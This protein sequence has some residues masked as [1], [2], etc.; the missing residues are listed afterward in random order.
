MPPPEDATA[1]VDL[2]MVGRA[3]MELALTSRYT[4][5]DD[6]P[7]VIS[8]CAAHLGARATTMY[9]VDLGQRDLVPLY[10]RSAPSGEPLPVE[11][12]LAGRA[13][14]H[15]E[16]V[17]TDGSDGVQLWVPLQDSAERA[18]VLSMT[19]DRVDASVERAALAFAA[20]AGEYTVSKSRYGDALERTRRRVPLT[21]PAEMRWAL[22][23]PLTY[24]SPAVSISGLVEPSYGIAGDTFDYAVVGDSVHLALFDAVGHGLLSC[25]VA[26]LAVSCYRNE[27]R[28][29][30]DLP[31]IYRALDEVVSTSF[32]D[33][34]FVTTILGELRIDTGRLRWI[35]AG[36]P[37]PLLLRGG[38]VVGDLP[39]RPSLPIGLG[40]APGTTHEHR[41]QPGDSIVF[42]TDGVIEARSTTGELFG[43]ARLVDH[44]ERAAAADAT[45]P[46][47]LRRLMASILDHQSNE[48]QDDATV[49]I[50]TW[51]GA[52]PA[53]PRADERLPTLAE[54]RE[55]QGTPEPEGD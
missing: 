7:E 25:R 9:L 51:H 43:E 14:R 32:G 4:H 13:Y 47:T 5:P 50:V 29:G 37:P 52:P 24:H 20:M 6:L 55:P 19:F 11:G 38:R 27:R 15:E 26:N 45:P 33:A 28:S 46:E 16:I 54:R 17:A 22:L 40:G 10:S 3:L 49:T 2:T 34:M 53:P 44:I 12:S 48:L 1:A 18:G 21:L 8:R 30:E 41:L 31:G 36:H 35:N 42:F 39:G 23:P